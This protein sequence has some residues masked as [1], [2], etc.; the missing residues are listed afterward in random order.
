MISVIVTLHNRESSIVSALQSI[1][2]QTAQV[3]ECVIVDNASTDS[4]EYQVRSYLIDRRMRY[5][6]LNNKVTT[7]Q[8]RQFGLNQIQG[9]WVMFLDG[10]DYLES[11]ALQAL[12][13]IVKKYGT[14]IGAGKYY[15]IIDGEKHISNT[16]LEGK[17]TPKQ[18]QKGKINLLTCNSIFS[19][20]IADK[21][22]T[23]AN[24]DVA[25]THHIIAYNGAIE[26]PH[27]KPQLPFWKRL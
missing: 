15:T 22:D 10:A 2:A 18:I 16:L 1:S 7:W 5:F 4:S 17:F 25:Y 3:W 8:A 27:I 9:D 13:L 23:W 6:R 14:Q 19:R 12:Y 24:F 26:E 20:E 11:N 21:P